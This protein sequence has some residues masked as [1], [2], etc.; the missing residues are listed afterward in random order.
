MP[1][2]TSRYIGL[3]YISGITEMYLR[4][5]ECIWRY[6]DVPGL[7]WETQSCT[8]TSQYIQIH[9]PLV[10]FRDQ[11]RPYVGNPILHKY[12]Q[13]HSFQN[14]LGHF[15]GLCSDILS[16]ILSGMYSDI[17][18][19]IRSRLRSGRAHRPTLVPRS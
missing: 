16:D 1:P 9:W 18:S 19:S 7:T 6:L 10:C 15:L 12:L 8:D 14:V 17:L 5:S 4:L 3:W 13:I 2:D 11:G